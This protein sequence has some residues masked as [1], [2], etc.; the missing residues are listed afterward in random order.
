MIRQTQTAMKSIAENES[1]K[2]NPLGKDT[3]NLS[4]NVKNE[5]AEEAKEAA[6]QERKKLSEWMREAIKDRIA[7]TKADAE[8]A[9]LLTSDVGQRVL[10]AFAARAMAE[11]GPITAERFKALM[12]EVKAETGAKGKELFHPVR[13]ALT[14][15]HSGPEFDK[16]VPL[17]EEGSALGLGVKSVAERAAAAF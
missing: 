8:N 15:A 13:I 11:P 17:M 14:G 3:C 7:K 4:V 5:L 2:T 12:N 1:S 9:A 6:W 10:G 16:I